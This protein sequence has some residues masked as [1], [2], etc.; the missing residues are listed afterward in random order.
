MA[1]M[2]QNCDLLHIKGMVSTEPAKKKSAICF[3]YPNNYLQNVPGSLGFLPI[4]ALLKKAVL[5]MLPVVPECLC[6][7]AKSQITPCRISFSPSP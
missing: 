6:G 7:A 4:S 1:A 2:H 3:I 5:F